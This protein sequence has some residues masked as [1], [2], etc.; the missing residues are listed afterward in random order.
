M[1]SIMSHVWVWLGSCALYIVY[2]S[3][4][5]FTICL[6]LLILTDLLAHTVEAPEDW[7]LGG[8]GA[9]LLLPLL[10]GHHALPAH[11]PLRLPPPHWDLQLLTQLD[12]LAPGE[13]LHPLHPAPRLLQNWRPGERERER[14]RE[15]EGERERG[16]EMER[17]LLPLQRKSAFLLWSRHR[18][19]FSPRKKEQQTFTCTVS[20]SAPN[21]QFRHRRRS[22][23]CT[24]WWSCSSCSIWGVASCRS[25]APRFARFEMPAD[26]EV[27]G[28]SLGDGWFKTEIWSH[29]KKLKPVFSEHGNLWPRASMI[30]S[31]QFP[32]LYSHYFAGMLQLGFDCYGG[33]LFPQS[34][35]SRE[36]F[37]LL[38]E[39]ERCIS[40]FHLPPSIFANVFTYC[41][42][43]AYVVF[44]NWG[45]SPLSFLRIN[46]SFLI[47][48]NAQCL[49]S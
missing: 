21:E 37:Y 38:Q 41:K 12:G 40:S 8:G 48:R 1:K 5:V 36:T 9:V 3:C 14:G 22:A 31:L 16:G 19:I 13:L 39:H 45:G 33:L 28:F 7:K 25:A 6:F 20:S 2:K 35:Q 24:S 49:F 18:E 43:K 10:L 46:S 44:C 34:P 29:P 47:C 32:H 15:R 42:K 4:T 11:W 23:R 27:K 26:T 30:S 17:E